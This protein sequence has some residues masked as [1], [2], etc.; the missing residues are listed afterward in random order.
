MQIEVQELGKKFHRE[1]IFRNVDLTFAGNEA[2]VFIGPNGSGKSTLMLTLTGLLPPTKGN[3]IY[4][5]DD[6]IIPDDEFYQHQSVVAPYM[7][8]V[9]EFTLQELL[10]FHFSF[11]R[12]LPGL[13][14]NHIM[15]AMYLERAKNKYIRQFS[16]G[17]KQRLK[18][19]MAFYSQSTVLFLDEPC[20]NLDAGGIQWYRME[21]QKAL[22]NKLIIICSNQPYEYDF[23][24]KVINIEQYK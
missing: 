10:D 2:Y 5:K 20:S 12:P 3:I 11:K 22:Q 4:K 16:S 23:C 8:V 9:E 1:W 14:V 21:A 15:E 7:E 24:E 6:Q 17:M 13:N 18:L 19:G